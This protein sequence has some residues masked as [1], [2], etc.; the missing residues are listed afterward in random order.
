MNNRLCNSTSVMFYRYLTMTNSDENYV[1][2]F[3]NSHYINASAV[4]IVYQYKPIIRA[5]PDRFF[6]LL[7]FFLRERVHGKMCRTSRFNDN[8]NK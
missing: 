3:L 6:Y 2:Q 7:I 5:K 4:K 8:R 1:R